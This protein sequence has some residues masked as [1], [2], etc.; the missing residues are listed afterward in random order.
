MSDFWWNVLNIFVIDA[1]AS[2]GAEHGAYRAQKEIENKKA[3]QRCVDYGNFYAREWAKERSRREKLEKDIEEIKR[4]LR[5]KT[6]L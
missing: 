4:M 1:A 2:H 5:G 6:V 3:A